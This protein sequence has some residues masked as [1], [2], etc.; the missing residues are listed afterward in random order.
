MQPAGLQQHTVS[1]LFS[2]CYNLPLAATSQH[3]TG[4]VIK[5]REEELI[6][7]PMLHRAL[8]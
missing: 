4:R 7:M 8:S 3:F 6:W 1:V 2:A 5:E